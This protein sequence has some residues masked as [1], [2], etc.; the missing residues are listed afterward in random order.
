[1]PYQKN[2]EF[3]P[4][5]KHGKKF[6]FIRDIKKGSSE[7]SLYQCSECSVQF[8]LPLKIPGLSWHEKNNFRIKNIIKPEICR[9]YHKRFLKIHKIFPKGTKVLD[10]GCAAGEFI[11]ELQKRGCEVWGADFDKEDIRIA[12]EYF[13]LKNVF[14]LSFKD[15]FKM[16]NLP[17]FDIV[18]LFAVIGYID[19]PLEFMGQVKKILKPGGIIVIN[20][21]SRERM[22]ADLNHWDF[23]PHYFTRWNK[24]SF[25]NLFEKHNFKI[26]FITYT[27]EFKT[28][29]EAV[30]GR[31]K[32]GLA[33]RAAASGNK[34]KSGAYLKII[35]F[36]GCFKDYII[37]TIPAGFLWIIGKIFRYNNG[38]IL[39]ELK[40]E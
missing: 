3:C 2:P 16:Q 38:E 31:F 26:S 27:E 15:F 33:G 29:Q 37:G 18:C 4:I 17:K 20:A 11:F 6:E 28:L 32:T 35:Y 39:I 13:G 7:F 1:M 8:W 5:C 36:L 14:A 25:S 34:R 19:D 24:E 9:G 12:K 22:L 40:Y 21:P 23:P 30:I 10:L